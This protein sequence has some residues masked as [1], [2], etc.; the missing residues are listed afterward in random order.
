MLISAG[1]HAFWYVRGKDV[2]I[3]KKLTTAVVIFWLSI[4]TI[5]LW[6]NL[7][8]EK[9]ENERLAFETA[10][11]FFH[12]VIITRMWNANHNGVYVPI[13][14]DTKPN[15]YLDDPSRDLT[16]EN[17]VKLTKINPA[18][19]IR[20]IAEIAAQSEGVK[21]HLIS[22]D[23]IRPDNTPTEDEKKW[24]RSFEEGIRERG[25]FLTEGSTSFF[26]YMAP[27]FIQDTCLKCHAKQG[28]KKGDVRGGISIII[29]YLSK[30]KYTVL[31]AGY[32]ITAVAGVILTIIGGA[33]L[34]KKK[35]LL[36]Q[37]NKSLEKKLK[38]GESLSASC[39]K[40]TAR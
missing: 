38:N 21:F 26:H 30:E 34:Q 12:Q 23:P 39:R 29:P 10:R 5:A 33:L 8:D 37:T 25:E 27:L 17:G 28:Y 24:L 3:M 22:L 14:E 6:W 4:V 16:T 18:Y 32:G 2:N 36:L 7:A 31:F 19:M 13:T 35:A 11:A 15:P 1:Q 20:Q 40:Q 9:T